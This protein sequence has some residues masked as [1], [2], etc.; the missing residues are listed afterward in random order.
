MKQVQKTN[1]LHSLKSRGDFILR[2]TLQIDLHRFSIEETDQ[3]YFVVEWNRNKV[4]VTEALGYLEQK[5]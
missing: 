3:L 5:F 4:L 2:M 1:R